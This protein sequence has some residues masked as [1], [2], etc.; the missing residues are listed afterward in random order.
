MKRFIPRYDVYWLPGSP[1]E[2]LVNSDYALYL[3]RADGRRKHDLATDPDVAIPSADG[4]QMLV[5]NRVFDSDGNYYRSAISIESIAT[6]KTAQLMQ[7]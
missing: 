1:R 7:R 5:V 4:K 3:I 6:G 2:L